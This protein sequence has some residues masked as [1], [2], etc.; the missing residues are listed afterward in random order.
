L[1]P[2]KNELDE[3]VVVAFGK[4]KKENVVGAI[5][6]INVKELKIP[7]SNLTTALAG[8]LSGVIAYQT[9]GE[10]GM[11]DASFFVRGVT[12]LAY[13]S[14]PLILIDGVESATSDLSRMQP[15]DIANFSIM[16]DATA[17]ALYG[18]R[19]ANGVIAITTK[20]GHEGQT[21]ISFRTETS[22]SMPTSRVDLADPVTYML[23]NNEAV[24]TRDKRSEGPYSQEKIDNTMNPDRNPYAYPANDWYNLLMNDQTVN[25]RANLNISGGGKIARYYIAA[26]FNQDNGN[27]R[28]DK[29][30]NFNNNINLKKYMLR[31][32]VDINMT[33]T[34]K[35]VVR[36]A[37]TFDDYRGPIDGG[38]ALYNKIVRSDPVLFPPTYAPDATTQYAHHIL[39]GNYQDAAYVNPYADMVK[40]YR[41]YNRSKM[42][43]QF[44]V[45]QELDFI[46]EGLAFRALYSTNRSSY[47]SMVRSYK[48]YYYSVANYDKATDIYT[49]QWLNSGQGKAEEWLSFTEDPKEVETTN[50]T[51]AAL[52]Y[53]RTF[54]EKH[55]LSGL[56][57]STMRN[58][59][60]YVKPEDQTDGATA[61]ELSLPHRNIGL[62]GRATY[63]YDNRYFTEFNFGYNGSER[64]ARHERFGFFPSVGV[65][66]TVSNEKFYPEKLTGFLP[67]FKLK[68]TYGLVGNDAIG[69]LQDRFYYLSKVEM[70]STGRS[71]AFGYDFNHTINGVSMT[72]YANDEITWEI[73]RKMNLGVEMNLFNK[74]DFIADFYTEDRSGILLPRINLGTMG[75]LSTMYANIGRATGRGID[76][77]LD[78][79]HFFKK[80]FWVTGRINYTYAT[81]KYT[82]Y[83][84]LAYLST[85]WRSFIGQPVSQTFGY[86]AERLFVD[87]YEVANSPAQNFGDT[88]G[89]MGGDIKYK[90]L[91]GDGKITDLDR[92]PIGFPTEPQ[93]VYGF[94][95]STGYKIFDFS[96][97]FQGLG[98]RSF[99]IDP[100]KTSPFIDTDDNNAVIS[101]NALLQVYADNH[102]SEDN[103]NLYALW[104]RLS[105]VVVKNNT[106][107]STWF[108]RDGSFLRLKSLELGCT[109]PEKITKKIHCKTFRIYFSGT[110]LLCFSKFKLWDPEMAGNGLGYPIQKVYNLG[111]QFTF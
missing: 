52:T 33:R 92:A 101:K 36:L 35:A 7:S 59:I 32:N 81:T 97:F 98:E 1:T 78:Y 109:I 4:Q 18:A 86:I 44:E 10:P 94:G 41:E 42:M 68:A 75:L 111:L 60:Q 93:L 79:Q 46:L 88:R 11:D 89:I 48:P 3:V 28:M 100:V 55:A 96:F 27:L 74:L 71:Y 47:Y 73:S 58:S 77:S 63:A 95:L 39:F 67:K 54:G 57:V 103:R 66:W 83:E 82:E 25:Y 87:D 110:N 99:W 49:L 38:S 72:R 17:T 56:L 23:L 34:T 50:Y 6:S 8:K 21:T 90:D 108:M 53:D 9:S 29:Q 12:S 45:K 70:N 5:T 16:K 14:G 105:D 102:W 51:E 104:P 20:G 80:D 43:A 30:N 69:K 84:E 85:P 40:G 76:M 13:A 2:Q 107:T 106:Q 91:D 61:L 15:D 37:G 19:G 64:F 62:S 22:L 26:T 31:S 24:L 65:A